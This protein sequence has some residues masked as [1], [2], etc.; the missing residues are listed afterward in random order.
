M[1]HVQNKSEFFLINYTK[2]NT[3]KYDI[4][5]K[6]EKDIDILNS[7]LKEKDSFILS[8]KRV[9]LQKYLFNIM[10]EKVTGA[11]IRA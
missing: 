8:S 6:L 10:P 5:D 9:N 3:K 1:G 11:Q 2:Q 4:T 7:A